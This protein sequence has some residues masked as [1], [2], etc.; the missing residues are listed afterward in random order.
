MDLTNLLL[1]LVFWT[2]IHIFNKSHFK[3]RKNDYLYGLNCWDSQMFQIDF[4][5]IDF[6]RRE[7]SNELDTF[8]IV[9]YRMYW[10]Y[11]GYGS[12]SS[13]LSKL[14]EIKG[15]IK[16]DLL[17]QARESK[18]GIHSMILPLLLLFM[19]RFSEASLMIFIGIL[20]SS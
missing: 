4:V 6:F 14:Q 2:S 18:Q 7:P 1:L 3:C 16:H 5:Q 9:T 12:V 19:F 11:G 8:P 13:I 20:K 15:K 17:S 10:N